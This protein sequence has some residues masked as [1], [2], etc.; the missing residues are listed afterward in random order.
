LSADPVSR[1]R[2]AFLAAIKRCEAKEDEGIDPDTFAE[3]GESLFWLVALAEARGRHK[4]ELLQGLGW[5]R[6]R[7]AHGVM[8]TAPVSWHYGTELG[9]WV[10]GRGAFGTSS[11]HEW[12]P[13]NSISTSRTQKRDPAGEAA[14]DKYVAG[15]RVIE[16]LHEGFAIALGK[17]P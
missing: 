2:L 15:R 8:L 14:Y 6:D 10:L 17:N 5:A 1:L 16:V 13:R 7:M 4:T 9:K 11:G 12:R 3:L